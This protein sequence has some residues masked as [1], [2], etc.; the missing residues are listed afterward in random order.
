VR[1]ALVVA[2]TAAA[3]SGGNDV[4]GPFSGPV[5]RYVIDRIDVPRDSEGANAV[6]AD[7]DG[8]AMPENKFGYATAVL[9]TTNDLSPHAADM[10]ASGALAS[11]LE[12]QAD[13]A[14]DDATVG[15][16]YL[17]ADG[18]AAVTIGGRLTGGS[19][20]SNRTRDTGHPGRATVRLPVFVNADPVVLV[21]DGAE[22]ELVGDGAGGFDG[23]LRGGIAERSAREAAHAGLVQMFETEPA[24]HLVFLRGVDEDADDVL[25]FAELEVSVIGLLV[26]ADIP[27]HGAD[28]DSVSIAF[29]FHASPCAAGRCSDAVPEVACRDRVRDGLETDVDCGGGC[30]RC[31]AGKACLTP[32]DCLSAGCDAGTCRAP[33][34]SDGVRDGY[35]SDV[36]CGGACPACAAT[37]VCAADRDC[38][39]GQ[40]AMGV[41]SVGTCN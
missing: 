41:G 17:G 7:L 12:V 33:T 14:S 19:F 29:G 36:D 27:L 15:A 38:A 1:L 11:V 16:R 3:C 21:V 8:D 10:I 26:S 6:A 30:Q 35:E 28:D 23:I 40:C 20:V 9:A 34:C 32:E 2:V 25:S 37:R 5:Q 4:V 24:R 31:A 13:D 18:D 39:S 22:L